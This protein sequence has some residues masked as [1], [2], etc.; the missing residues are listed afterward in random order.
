MKILIVEDDTILL[1]VLILAAQTE[2]YECDGVSTE[3]A[4][5]HSLDSG[6]YSL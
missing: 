4:A 2:G 1:K 3:R 5:E 6:H